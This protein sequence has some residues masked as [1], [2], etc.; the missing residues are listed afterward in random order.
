MKIFWKYYGLKKYMNAH[1]ERIGDRPYITS[2][3]IVKWTSAK[4]AI[5]LTQPTQS[6]SWLNLGMVPYRKKRLWD[7]FAKWVQRRWRGVCSVRCRRETTLSAIFSCLL[8]MTLCWNL[9]VLLYARR[10]S[11]TMDFYSTGQY[12]YKSGLKPFVSNIQYATTMDFYSI[13]KFFI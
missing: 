7:I 9:H 1:S 10:Y 5:F 11:T 13:G 4:I 12:F 3:S 8:K 2:E 6:F